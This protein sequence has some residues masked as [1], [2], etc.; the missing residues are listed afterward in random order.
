VRVPTTMVGPALVSMSC[1]SS[2]LGAA[3]FAECKAED[4]QPLEPYSRK[5]KFY[6][7]LFGEFY[8]DEKRIAFKVEEP[9]S[10]WELEDLNVA[11]AGLN[12]TMKESHLDGS[13]YGWVGER[14]LRWFAESLRRAKERG[15]FRLGVVHHNVLRGAQDDDENLRDADD[16]DRLLAPSL[17]LLLHGHTHNGRIGWLRSDLP[18]LSTGS[19]ALKPEARPHEVPNQYQ[20]LRIEAKRVDRWTRRYDPDHKRWEGDTRCSEDGNSWHLQHAVAFKAVHGVFPRSASPAQSKKSARKNRSE[21]ERKRSRFVEREAS[22][23]FLSR[24]ADICKLRWRGADVEIRRPADSRPGYV[25]VRAADAPRIFPVGASEQGISS[26]AI[27]KF[28]EQVFA[29]Y[30]ASDPQLA[31]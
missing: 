19:A 7:W 8:K 27:R 9:W 2:L 12:S 4:S 23:D 22:F 21:V 18:V 3:Y 14:Q 20:A 17:N 26:E 25:I 16:L 13:H 6:E 31:L 11:V 24:V 10:I 5:W 15:W 29:Q 1:A 30:R 28:Q